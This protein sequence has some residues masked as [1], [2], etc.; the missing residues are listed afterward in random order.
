VGKFVIVLE[1]M[2]SGQVSIVASGSP[3]RDELAP[4]TDA[5]ELF[6]EILEVISESTEGLT[7]QCHSHH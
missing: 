3:D 6:L 5:E 2:P 7:G 4:P 1:D